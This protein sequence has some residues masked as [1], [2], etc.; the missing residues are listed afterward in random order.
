MHIDMIGGSFLS[1]Q[2]QACAIMLWMAD[3][4]S[5]LFYLLLSMH[6]PSFSW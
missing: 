3:D 4:Y 6:K 5:K 1:S 2:E